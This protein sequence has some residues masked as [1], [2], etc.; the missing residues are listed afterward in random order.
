MIQPGG[1]LAGR[2]G[3]SISPDRGM[4]KPLFSGVDEIDARRFAS[5]PSFWNLSCSS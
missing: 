4:K 3:I 5:G 1:G 2:V